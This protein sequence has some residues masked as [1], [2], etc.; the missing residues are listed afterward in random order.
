MPKWLGELLASPVNINKYS[1][2]EAYILVYMMEN[3]R[4]PIYPK[5]ILDRMNSDNIERTP[6]AIKQH[7]QYLSEPK[8]VLIL[9]DK[10]MM[11]AYRLPKEWQSSEYLEKILKTLDMNMAVRGRFSLD[12]QGYYSPTLDVW[13]KYNPLN[14]VNNKSTLG[15]A[16][17]RELLEN[18]IE[19]ATKKK[20]SFLLYSLQRG[21]TFLQNKEGNRNDITIMKFVLNHLA[22]EIYTRKADLIGEEGKEIE[23]IV[24]GILERRSFHKPLMRVMGLAPA[25]KALKEKEKNNNQPSVN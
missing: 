21:E 7:L 23:R 11:D 16:I 24:K 9:P 6:R 25:L 3:S 5:Q 18:Y 20:A 19:F 14:K 8:V 15:E 4:R 22:G 17:A 10:K 12:T 2:M 1:A 13:H